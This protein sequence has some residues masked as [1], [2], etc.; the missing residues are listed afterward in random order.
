MPQFSKIRDSCPTTK[1]RQCNARHYV[2]ISKVTSSSTGHPSDSL[3]TPYTTQTEVLSGPKISRNS[4]EAASA[5]FGRSTESSPVASITPRRTTREIWVR[6]PRCS[7]AIANAFSAA[8]RVADH[9]CSALRSV[10]RRPRYC[11][12]PSSTGKVPLKNN[13]L[14]DRTASAYAPNGVGSGGSSIP[15][16]AMRFSASP[17]ALSVMPSPLA[18]SGSLYK[19]NDNGRLS[20]CLFTRSVQAHRP[21]QDN[22]LGG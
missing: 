11:G 15:I 22:D 18:E 1:S 13:K 5:T 21:A 4:S 14:P 3:A 20:W 17:A 2:T 12:R 19:S 10:P 9:A 7:L 6:D 16:S 8:R